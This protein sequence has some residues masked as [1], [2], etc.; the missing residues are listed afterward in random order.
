MAGSAYPLWFFYPSPTPPPEWAS[1]FV[2][3]V[4][5]CRPWI[6]SSAIDGLTSHWWTPRRRADYI[7]KRRARVATEWG[8]QAA[9]LWTV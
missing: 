9:R 8:T 4:N 5:R 3:V 7:A 2:D 1:D 6:E